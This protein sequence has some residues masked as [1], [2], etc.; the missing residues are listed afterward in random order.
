MR[1]FATQPRDSAFNSR[2]PRQ[3]AE[4]LSEDEATYDLTEPGVVTSY[5][6]R[7]QRY[8][9]IALPSSG[10]MVKLRSLAAM[11]LVR[12]E[13]VGHGCSAA[14]M[15]ARPATADRKG[16]REPRPTAVVASGLRME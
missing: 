10:D 8:R 14:R 15:E 13:E 1:Q 7:H 4:R 12:V 3:S 2:A 9:R 5:C 16:V 11:S 6:Q